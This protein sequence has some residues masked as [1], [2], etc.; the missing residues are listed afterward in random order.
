MQSPMNANGILPT[1]AAAL[2]EIIRLLIETMSSQ[3]DQGPTSRE[4]VASYLKQKRAEHG[5]GCYAA[6]SVR[7]A[8]WY[9]LS[10]LAFLAERAD[11]PVTIAGRKSDLTAWVLAHPEWVSSHTKGDAIGVV[12]TCFRWAEQEPLI[13]YSPYR[14]PKRTLW[15]APQP[16]AAITEDEYGAI[17]NAA[18][19][20]DGVHGRTRPGRAAFRRALFFLHETGCRTCEMRQARWRDLDREHTVLRLLKHKTDK[21][22]DKPRLIPLSRAVLAMLRTMHEKRNP[23]PTDFIFVHSRNRPWNKEQFARRFSEYRKMANVRPEI[24]PYSLRH[25]FVVRGLSNG[26]G[27]RQIADCL[28]HVTTRH[29]SWYA[30]SSRNNPAYLSRVVEQIQGNAL[31]SV[32]EPARPKPAPEPTPVDSCD[33]G[34]NARQRALLEAV[35]FAM[36]QEPSL[37]THREVF[38]WL[39]ARPEY[40]GVLPPTAVTFRRQV[41]LARKA[42][43]RKPGYARRLTERHRLLVE[44]VERAIAE[45]PALA[46]AARKELF[47]WMRQRPEYRAVLPGS[48]STFAYRLCE[49]NKA[50]HVD[51][52]AEKG[53]VA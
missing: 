31:P 1:D 16:R 28:G 11:Q 5:A 50:G 36:Q 9:L 32:P 35:A 6:N 18:K 26:V 39:R 52:A 45:E 43:P 17:M 40:R 8:E 22:V 20:C 25:G 44:A 7:R 37:A 21:V 29:T 24:S 53:G 41:A 46:N 19:L 30:A 10:F 3:R 23:A 48:L 34:P 38:D 47:A 33:G 51:D 15:A 13:P 4:I 12:V 14:R 42:E 49:V 27:E 2:K